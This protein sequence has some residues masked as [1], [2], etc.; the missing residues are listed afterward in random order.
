MLSTSTLQLLRI[1]FSFFLLPVFLFAIATAPSVS[2]SSV[3][4]LFVALHLFVYPASNGYNSYMDKDETPI[5]LIRKP[6]QPTKQLYYTCLLMDICGIMLVSLI[7]FE[8]VYLLLTYIIFSR[9]YSYRGIRLKRFAVVGY[10]TVIIN[11]GALIY[12]LAYKAIAGWEPPWI[13]VVVATLFIGGFYPITQVYQHEADKN[14][15]VRTFS[16]LLG[17]RGTF[18]WCAL[19]YLAAMLGLFYWFN[20]QNNL[21]MFWVLQLC[22]LPV[23]TSFLL[24]F[25][26]VW[27]NEGNATFDKT[28]RMNW[29]ASAGTNLGFLI[30]I[31]NNFFD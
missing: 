4:I 9:L 20:S 29:L 28:M 21:M 18:I 10:L 14:D 5:G 23:V 3:V 16:M 7:N 15:G 22:F 1:P 8:T 24:W 2:W 27:Q 12:Y 11:Q 13:L 25:Y 19:C 6:L 31:I 30:I 26:K 17:I